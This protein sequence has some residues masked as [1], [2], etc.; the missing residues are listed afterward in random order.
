M[1]T[2]EYRCDA[3]DARFEAFQSIKSDP[4]R[5]CPQC[6]AAG[7]VRRLIGAGAGIIFKG[8]GFYITDYR[9]SSYKEAAKKDNG[10]SSLSP[11]SST[12][13]GSSDSKTPAATAKSS[14]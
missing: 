10:S 4:I 5:D 1:P 7:A 8:S 2:Y 11:P 9:S 12:S 14:E 6:R 3:C 13:S